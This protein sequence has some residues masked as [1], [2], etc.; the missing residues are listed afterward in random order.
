LAKKHVRTAASHF[1]NGLRSSAGS[2]KLDSS[3]GIG[4]V[5]RVTAILALLTGC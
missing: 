5:T 3:A 1:Q 2:S 4:H